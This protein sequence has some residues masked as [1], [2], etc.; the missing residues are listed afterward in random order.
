ML[1]EEVGLSVL[2]VLAFANGANDVGKSVASL[3]SSTGPGV[4]D[5]A[6]DLYSGEG[7]SAG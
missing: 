5:W 7:S 2:F 1:V 3:M 6:D 4:P